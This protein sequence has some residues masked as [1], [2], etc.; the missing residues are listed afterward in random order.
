LSGGKGTGVPDNGLG[1]WYEVD[2][3]KGGS[4]KLALEE[5]LA[6]VGRRRRL[7]QD[8]KCIADS[9]RPFVCHIWQ[10]RVAFHNFIDEN[11]HRPYQ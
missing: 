4:A 7:L 6:T 5:T 10:K 1:E 3:K 8:V 11:R 2:E 9:F